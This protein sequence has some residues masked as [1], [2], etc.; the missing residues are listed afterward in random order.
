VNVVTLEEDPPYQVGQRVFLA[1][2]DRP[3]TPDVK[4][5]PHP[6]ARYLV[7]G[8]GVLQAVSPDNVSLS[9]S[10]HPV[11]DAAAAAQGKGEIATRPNVQKRVT[12]PGMPSTG[13]QISPVVFS[14]L[15][16]AIIL[17]AIGLALVSFVPRLIPRR[18]R[19]E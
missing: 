4:Q 2:E 7:D 8:N 16:L 14:W 1:L 5:I 10:G 13:V 12:T 17:V 11:A 6:A 9:V 3:G 19:N 15:G 18:K